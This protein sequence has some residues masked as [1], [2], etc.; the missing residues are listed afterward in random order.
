MCFPLVILVYPFSVPYCL[1][2]FS[3][4]ASDRV[5]AVWHLRAIM[6]FLGR[7]DGV[8]MRR[9]CVSLVG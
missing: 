6:C 4:V 7:S 2:V 3:P 1:R 8:M 5:L 9:N